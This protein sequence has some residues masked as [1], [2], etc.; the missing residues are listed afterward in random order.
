MKLLFDEN[1]SYLLEFLLSD[2]GKLFGIA[3]MT[4]IFGNCRLLFSHN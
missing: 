3:V 4:A 1:L 2:H